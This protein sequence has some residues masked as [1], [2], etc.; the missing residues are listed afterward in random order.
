M[1]LDLAWERKEFKLDW[2]HLREVQPLIFMLWPLHFQ[3][4]SN[5]ILRLC[6]RVSSHTYL[7]LADG[8]SPVFARSA[9]PVPI[10]GPVKDRLRPVLDRSQPPCS[11]WQIYQICGMKMVPNG[12]KMGLS[13]IKSHTAFTFCYKS[14]KMRH[15]ILQLNTIWPERDQFGGP[16]LWTSP[17]L[18][19]GPKFRTAGPVRTGPSVIPAYL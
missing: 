2:E 14:C 7:A 10:S 1:S 15:I 8:H 12:S 4:I 18:G 17:K 11:S 5:T 13:M 9:G 3:Q 6:I 19:P 16:V